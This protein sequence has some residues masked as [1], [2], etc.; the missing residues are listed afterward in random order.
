MNKEQYLN[1]RQTLMTEAENL[2]K[3]GKVK[4]AEAK[5]K[6]IEELDAT[7]EDAAKAQANLNALRGNAVVTNIANK[8]THVN[9]VATLGDTGKGPVAKNDKELYNVA[10]A[11]TLMGTA[12]SNEETEVFNEVNAEF[13]KKTHTAEEYQ[14]L[15]PETVVAGIWKEIGDLHPILSD[16][17]KMNIPGNVTFL[18][19]NKKTSDADW[20]DEG[21]Q[22][23][24]EKLGFAKLELT[25]CE[26]IKSISV[27]WKMKKMSIDEFIPYITS[28]LAEAMA[29]SIAYGVVRG[30]GK[31]GENGDWK[32]QARG[33]ITA[34]EAEEGTP[35]IHSTATSFAY[36]DL[37]K[38][39]GS[40]KSGYSAGAVIYANNHTIWN[41]LA[42][43]CDATG[44]PYFVP[45]PVDGGVGRI[46]GKVVKEEDA[47]KD[48]EVLLASVARGY[49]MNE[50]E[51][52]S[53]YQ[54]DHV[55]QRVTDY[56]AYAIIDG[57]VMTTKAFALLKKQ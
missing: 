3:E 13:R 16:L 5:M 38:L 37:T 6:Q 53:I 14:I 49:K 45:N 4:E 25:G 26:L 31:P 7:F 21:D 15:V 32:A 10:F 17:R 44:R 47:M 54:E 57:D 55:K 20:V 39:M 19:S 48:G 23:N 9:P 33:I 35:R 34:L 29:G 46:L 41:E 50:N 52:I 43:I 1:K 30:K 40:I 11:K 56:M 36:E 28:E 18:K 27:T 22:P 12:L 51:S 24:D 8:S 42:T 2:I